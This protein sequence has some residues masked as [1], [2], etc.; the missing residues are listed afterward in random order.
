MCH[1][2]WLCCFVFYFKLF[3]PLQSNVGYANTMCC[4]VPDATCLITVIYKVTLYSWHDEAVTVTIKLLQG[5]HSEL[6]PGSSSWPWRNLASRLWDSSRVMQPYSPR[7]SVLVA[8]FPLKLCSWCISHRWEGERRESK[9]GLW[10]CP[11]FCYEETIDSKESVCLGKTLRDWTC[12]RFRPCGNDWPNH[13]HKGC[14]RQ[15]APEPS[16]SRG[17]WKREAW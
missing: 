12:T 15:T 13:C 16:V 14:I 5:Q 17:E 2:I 8:G 11:G 1:H 4:W 9:Q 10:L 7:S 3:P 6:I